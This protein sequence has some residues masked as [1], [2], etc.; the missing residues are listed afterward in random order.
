MVS[1]PHH[2]LLHI[3]GQPETQRPPYC[4]SDILDHDMD[5]I[6]DQKNDQILSWAYEQLVVVNG[7]TVALQQAE[8]WPYLKIRNEQVYHLDKTQI[9]EPGWWLSWLVLHV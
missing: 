9:L 2:S 1:G 4:Q 7:E 6:S 5:L 8:Q 3:L